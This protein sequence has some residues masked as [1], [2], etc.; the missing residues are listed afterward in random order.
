MKKILVIAISALAVITVASCTKDAL[1]TSPTDSVAS[2]T[3][4]QD[5]DGGMIALNGAYR[6]FWA[7]GQSVNFNQHQ[8][9]G[10]QGY[11]LMGDLMG[12]DMV[13]S[14]S[15]NGWFWNDYLYTVKPYYTNDGWRPYDCWNFYYTLISQVNYIIAAQ[16]TMEGSEEDVN[17][18]VGNSYALRAYAYHYLAMTYARSYIG[19]E[20]NLSVPIYTEPTVAGSPGKARSTNKEVY[21][22]AMTD[23][24]SAII[25]LGNAPKRHV[26]H[27]DA[28]VANGIKARMA[29][30]MGEWQTALD[31]AKIAA[32]GGKMTTDV[33]SGYNNASADDV[34]WGAEIISSQ[35]T[36]NPQFLA[37]MDPDFGGYGDAARK[38]AS[39]WLYD[40]IKDTDSRKA[41]F[42]AD[43]EIEPGKTFYQQKKFQFGNKD[44]QGNVTD[45]LT[46]AD[47]IFM[48]VPE[49]LLIQAEC[50]ARL[51][52]E[53]GAKS[54]LNN[55]MSY[56]DRTYSC[57]G[58]NGL[59]LA[60]LTT[61]ETGSLLEEIILQRRIELWG[62]YGRIYDIKRLRQGFKRTAD[63]GH[64]ATALLPS[65]HV[66]DPETFDWVLTIP[67]AELDANSLMVQN[68]IGSYPEGNMG[69]DPSLNP[70]K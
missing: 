59:S 8:S 14:S 47:H 10:P 28:H 20:N 41:W 42:V 39:K 62:E 38:C 31:A 25:L 2:N 50:Q 19:H 34:L 46:G 26:S 11:A 7:W 60:P 69:D 32:A 23:I 63:M 67:Q 48:R 40:K 57:D 18:I 43:G 4:L 53:P 1:N 6:W 45:P 27:I 65:I 17:Y 66:D 29:L 44:A 49:M 52:D 36:T 68:P 51:G 37:H 56:R 15:G 21:E 30:Y 16:H 54:T 5:T 12:E 58:L 22:R 64:P 55:F 70:A 61:T 3:M 35:G 13:M 24:D 9:F 33:T